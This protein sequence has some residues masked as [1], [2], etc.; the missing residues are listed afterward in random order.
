VGS[1]RRHPARGIYWAHNTRVGEARA[2]AMLSAGRRNIGQMACTGPGM[3]PVFIVG[4]STGEGE[5][6]EERA[7]L[8][9]AS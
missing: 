9:N 5:F 4:F 7:G 8:Q 2:T 3:E 6:L 1:L